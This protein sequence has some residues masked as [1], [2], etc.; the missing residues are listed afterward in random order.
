MVARAGP[1]LVSVTVKVIVSPTL[2]VALVDRLGDGQVGL[3]RPL[4]RDGGIV[5]GARVELVG[6]G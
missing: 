3:L 2:G 6:C 1:R 5:A 4:G